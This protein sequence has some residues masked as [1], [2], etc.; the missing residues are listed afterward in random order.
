MLLQRKR[1]YKMKKV[2]RIHM[3]MYDVLVDTNSGVIFQILK[4]PRGR[5]LFV[6]KRSPFPP[7]SYLWYTR[8]VVKKIRRG[9]FKH[10]RG[11][12]MLERDHLIIY[13]EKGNEK[14]IDVD[15]SSQK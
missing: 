7:T 13:D 11:K 15:F 6:M 14:R 5:K 8:K 10:Y 1:G 9:E 4:Y 12:A 3:R 2:K